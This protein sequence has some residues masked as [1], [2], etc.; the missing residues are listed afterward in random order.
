M[1]QCERETQALKLCTFR[2]KDYLSLSSALCGS[3]NILNSLCKLS[4]FSSCSIPKSKIAF[5]LTGGPEYFRLLVNNMYIAQQIDIELC[6]FTN[7]F[8]QFY[9]RWLKK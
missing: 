5:F 1:H 6:A 8:L 2:E 3:L 9:S 7:F 4:V